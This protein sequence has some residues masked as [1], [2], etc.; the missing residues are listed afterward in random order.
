VKCSPGGLVLRYSFADFV[1]F[2]LLISVPFVTALIAILQNAS[3]YWWAAGYLGVIGWH[4]NITYRIFCTKCPHY[5]LS[6]GKTQ[7]LMIWNVPKFYK[8]RPGRPSTFVSAFIIA[9]IL[10]VTAYPLYWLWMDWRF[11]TV[12]LLSWSVFIV[13]LVKNECSRCIWFDCAKNNV[14]KEARESYLVS[15]GTGRSS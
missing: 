3:S 8:A 13:S 4:V 15:L 6:E 14:P 11:F 9:D 12:Y 10:L 5:D 2:K 1:Y 7:C